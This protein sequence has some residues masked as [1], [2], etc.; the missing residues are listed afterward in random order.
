MP[1]DDKNLGPIVAGFQ[2]NYG[3]SADGRMTRIV[4]LAP[5]KKTEIPIQFAADILSKLMPFL[6]QIHG[7]CERRY[8]GTN[9]KLVYR[10]REGSIQKATTGSDD[11]V[12]FEFTI[13]T[14]QSFAFE[15]DKI[16]AKLLHASLSKVLGM[17]EDQSG[18]I[19]TP[20][21]Q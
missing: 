12:V 10:I 3:I 19:E 6:L 16:G 17:V 11:V 9:E 8:K 4:F 7:E 14:G 15:V 21:R 1:T 20:T 5:D 18:P 13:S 2:H